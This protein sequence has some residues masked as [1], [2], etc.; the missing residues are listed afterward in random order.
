MKI[1]PTISCNP[2][3]SD[4][5]IEY[6]GQLHTRLPKLYHNQDVNLFY[7]HKAM[8]PSLLSDDKWLAIQDKLLSYHGR[9][10]PVTNYFLEYEVGSY[11]RMHID[12][13][14]TVDATAITLIGKS[15][16]LIGGDI[17]TPSF[18]SS[19]KQP[20]ILPQEIGETMYYYSNTPHGV[21]K[22]DKGNRKVL[23]TWF[24]KDTWQK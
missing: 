14:E 11:A 16:D 15:D 9:K 17:I 7:V 1:L 18:D 10:C 22:V 4:S 6:L 24:R 12:N 8:V 13:T 3:L 19:S 21:S 20:R 2:I 5:E 23:V